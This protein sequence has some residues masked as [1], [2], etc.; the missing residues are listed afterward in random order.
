MLSCCF[1]AAVIAPPR[2]E[3]APPPSLRELCVQ[4]PVVVLARPIDPVTPTRFTVLSVL[5]GKGI[6]PGS[7]L[8]PQ[9]LAEKD[10][11]SYDEVNPQ[12]KKPRPRLIDQALLFLEPVETKGERSGYRVLEAGFRLCTSDGRVLVPAA[13]LNEKDK[14]KDG[15]RL[16]VVKD[17]EWPAIVRRVRA[18]LRS[19]DH[20]YAIRDHARPGQRTRG[21]LD[22]IEKRRADFSVLPS[23]R[24][25]DSVPLGWGRLGVDIYDWIFAAAPPEECWAAVRL[26]AS[27][28]RGATPQLKYPSFST[29]EGRKYLVAQ[30]TNDRL[31]TGDR[32]RALRL[33]TQP[34][35]LRPPGTPGRPAVKAIDAAER[36]TLL[37]AISPLVAGKDEPLQVEAIRTVRT[38]MPAARGTPALVSSLISAY[39][40]AQPGPGRD[41]VAQALCALA[42]TEQYKVLTNNPAGFCATLN[43]FT[44]DGS[45][46]TFFLTMQTGDAKVFEQP[47]LV[48]E[49]IG[50]LGIIAETKRFPLAVLNLEGDWPDGIGAATLAARLDVTKIVYPPPTGARPAPNTAPTIWRIRVEGAVGKDKGRR[51]WKSEPRKI[52]VRPLP[53]GGNPNIYYEGKW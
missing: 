12:T 23:G 3:P 2:S 25:S 17:A 1:L 5:R 32:R 51:T 29:P 22:W 10:V 19:I 18:D 26:Y 13:A 33:L 50:T 38:L 46:I 47:T 4:A 44:F 52:A 45:E 40:A 15:E 20:L 9:G 35:T 43:D 11:K 31:V 53:P 42:E 39:K 14:A 6:G 49:K 34:I 30:A 28:E 37:D 36:K 16:R 24:L 21:L 27:H 48:L 8:I 41:E 7:K